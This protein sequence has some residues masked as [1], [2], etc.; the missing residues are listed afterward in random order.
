MSVYYKNGDKYFFGNL[1]PGD[2]QSTLDFYNENFGKYIKTVKLEKSPSG[3]T[4][5]LANGSGFYFYRYNAC[6]SL[7]T[8]GCIYL[9]FCPKYNDCKEL[10]ETAFDYGENIVDGKKSFAFYTKGEAPYSRWN[11]LT[12]ANRTRTW[13]KN[14]C[15]TQH[16]YC[17]KLIEY[18]GWEIKDDYPIKL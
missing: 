6:A 8:N 18:D 2:A 16:G 9:A 14:T 15:S 1:Q 3:I 11:A 7:S 13:L 5:A 10:A 12:P 17:T 4:G